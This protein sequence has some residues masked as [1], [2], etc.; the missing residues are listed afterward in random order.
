MGEVILKLSPL[1]I[2]INHTQ[3]KTQQH[4]ADF[5][6]QIKKLYQYEIFKDMLDLVA[7]LA[8]KDRLIFKIDDRK[9]FELDEGNCKT[10]EGG[11]F[12]Q[13]LNRFKSERSYVITIKKISVPVIVH[14]IAHMIEK[15]GDFSSLDAFVEVIEKD[16]ARRDKSNLALIST[17][18]Q[19]F[20][21]E[22]KNYHYSQRASEYFA[23]FFQ[24]IAT[25]REVLGA[26]SSFKLEDCYKFFTTTIEHLSGSFYNNISLKIDPHIKIE[27]QA[28]IK[29]IDKIEYKWQDER[30][31]PKHS[32]DNPKWSKS[33]R[34][35]KDTDL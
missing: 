34:S 25:A 30:I 31:K 7:T 27:S 32:G 21:E 35:I 6:V 9:F 2:I 15:E 18:R 16:L 3:A 1:D 24:I 4:L 26:E 8:N 17:V 5:K 11:S 12:N 28:Y 33:I 29:P 22:V 23:R 13:F 20:E 14:E 19:I 10:I